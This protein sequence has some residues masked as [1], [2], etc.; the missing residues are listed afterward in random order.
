MDPSFK[1]YFNK[2][3]SSLD[4]IHADIRS[5]AAKLEDLVA[6]RPELERRVDRL[7]IAVAELQ[8]GRPAP[9]AAPTLVHLRDPTDDNKGPEGGIASGPI[10]HGID[11]LPRGLAPTFASVSTPANGA[12]GGHTGDCAGATTA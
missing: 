10:G 5:T 7:S 8:Q 3:T 6:W 11:I 12:S 4:G 1:E 2:L 9:K